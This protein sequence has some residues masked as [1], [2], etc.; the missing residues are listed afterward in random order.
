M[1]FGEDLIKML[2]DN[3]KAEPSDSKPE[4]ANS[5]EDK[6]PW[7]PNEYSKD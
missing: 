5:T 1:K 7:N 3:K 2:G 4:D 6:K